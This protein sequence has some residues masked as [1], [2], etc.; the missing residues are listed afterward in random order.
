MVLPGFRQAVVGRDDLLASFDEFCRNARVLEYRETD[1]QVQVVNNCAV[2]SFRFEM[3]YER[4]TYRATSSGRDLWVFEQT[5][6]QWRGVWRTMLELI[7]TREPGTDATAQHLAR[8][9]SRRVPG[10]RDQP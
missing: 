9:D 3:V 4:A 10:D 7:E 6:G 5:G 2:A 1:E 8:P